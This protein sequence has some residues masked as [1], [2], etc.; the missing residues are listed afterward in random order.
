MH[1]YYKNACFRK[2][3]D[4]TRMEL[5]KERSDRNKL[6]VDFVALEK[7]KTALAI[8]IRQKEKEV[9]DKI[10]LVKLQEQI[11]AESSLNK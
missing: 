10:S 2:Q 9:S 5:E 3:L 1:Q 8:E 6:Q 11:E 7:E 4:A